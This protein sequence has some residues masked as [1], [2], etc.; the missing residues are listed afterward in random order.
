MNVFT[1]SSVELRITLR[2]GPL[3]P[4]WDRWD[5]TYASA[6]AG[7]ETRR[8]LDRLRLQGSLSAWGLAEATRRAGRIEAST[9]SVAVTPEVLALASQPMP[10][11]VRTLDAIHLASAVLVRDRID[12]L[13][14]FATHDRQQAIAAA[15]MGFQVL[16]VAV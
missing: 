10:T 15:A 8:V 14:V 13:L 12:A 5:R 2:D 1:D 16:G 3:I 4:D 9:S 11:V 6:L 7:V